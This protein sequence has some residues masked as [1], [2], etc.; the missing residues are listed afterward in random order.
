LNSDQRLLAVFSINPSLKTLS[1]VVKIDSKNAV[2]DV[3]VPAISASVVAEK[4]AQIHHEEHISIAPLQ[5][6]K[7]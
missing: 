3:A 7:F 1:S 4:K 2:E 6:S 5:L